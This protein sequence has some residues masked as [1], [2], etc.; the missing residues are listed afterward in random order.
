MNCETCQSRLAELIDGK[1]DAGTKSEVRTH[2]DGC[3]DCQRELEALTQTLAALDA[4][5]TGAPSPQLR[6]RVTADIEA[7]KLTQRD[8]ANGPPRSARRP[9][10][11][12]GAPPG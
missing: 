1:L 12:P 2:L 7:E 9:S 6:A 10:A 4:L 5:P 8:H 3:A 11:R